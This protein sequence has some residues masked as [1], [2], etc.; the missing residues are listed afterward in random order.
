MKILNQAN[1]LRAWDQAPFYEVYFLKFH[2][3]EENLAFWIRYTL[4]RPLKGLAH[5]SLWAFVFDANQP[6]RN[7]GALQNFEWTE[8]KSAPKDF[9]LALG[10]SLLNLEK[11]KG[12]VNDSPFSL[13]WDLNLK[14]NENPLLLFPYEWMYKIKSFPKTKYITSRPHLLFSGTLKWKGKEYSVKEAPGMQAHLWGTQ[15]VHRFL[16]SHC[17]TF[18]EDPNALFEGLSSQVMLGSWLAPPLGVFY[19]RMFGKEYLLN[20]PK[21]WFQRDLRRDLEE[22]NFDIRQEEDRFVGAVGADPEQFLGVRY[23][24]PVKDF[25]YCNHAEWAMLTLEHYKLKSGRWCMEGVVNSKAATYEW[26]DSEPHKSVEVRVL[27]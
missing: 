22:W 5:A 9:E 27:G 19:I 18:L 3:I 2:L 16:W 12:Q 20:S 25:R 6:S 23:T 15:H 10:N 17:N 1:E 13:E 21:I 14:S 8:M 7:S 26:V 11:C 4:H 24:D